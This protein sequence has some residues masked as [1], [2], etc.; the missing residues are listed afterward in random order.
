VLA[1]VLL[2]PSTTGFPMNAH[3]AASPSE[4][5][6]SR[7]AAIW[8]IGLAALSLAALALAATLL[9]SNGSS[10]PAP[11]APTGIVRPPAA[12]AIEARYGIRVTQIG[13]TADGGMLDMRFVA[14]DPDIAEQLSH[15]SKVHMQL[16]VEDGDRLLDSEA[17]APHGGALHAGSTYFTLFRNDGGLLR[18]GSRVTLLIGKLRLEHLVVL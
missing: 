14:I 12:P 2:P 17:M 3:T 13:L 16:V 15:G 18:H 11:V 9:V 6:Q 7:R 8:L 5:L 1:G 4:P 10:G